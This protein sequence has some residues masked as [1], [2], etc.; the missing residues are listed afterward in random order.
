MVACLAV[1]GCSPRYAVTVAG[2]S[3][4]GAKSELTIQEL[5]VRNLVAAEPARDVV[6]IS[7]GKSRHDGVDPPPSFFER[8]TDLKA[9]LRPVS[10]YHSSNTP[11]A[12]LL[13]VH[14]GEMTSD[15]EVRVEVTRFRYGVGASDGFTAQVQ[16]HDGVWKIVRTFHQ[17]ST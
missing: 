15:T 14:V 1:G 16:W 9:S 11:N 4:Q 5:L 3:G 17:W 2:P 10:Q 12:L 13:V 7:F 6:L 8:L